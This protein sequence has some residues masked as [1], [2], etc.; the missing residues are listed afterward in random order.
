M[1][2]ARNGASG[3]AEGIASPAGLALVLEDLAIR[4]RYAT[5]DVS[6]QQEKARAQLR[7]LQDHHGDAWG[8]M[9]AVAEAFGVAW[10]AAQD[11]DAAIACYSRALRAEDA[12]ASVKAH[13]Q[14]GKLLIER[15]WAIA[16]DPGA[17]DATRTL[18]REELA[19]ALR[20]LQTLVALQP[21]F[22][23][24][25][26]LG[27]AWQRQAQL[28]AREGLGSESIGSLGMAQDAYRRAEALMADASDPRLGEAGL[29]RMA[30][31]LV[32]PADNKAAPNLDNA[33]LARTRRSVQASHDKQPDF[34]SHADL[35]LVDLFEALASNALAERQPALA[36]AYAALQAQVAAVPRWAQVLDGVGWVLETP[37][38]L[39]N[40]AN[41]GAAGKL[42]RQL[43]G[44]AQQ[45]T[46]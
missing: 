18:M 34:Q 9:G 23:R 39:K 22:E 32:L 42:L 20:E 41:R 4:T 6:S 45:Q 27:L 46:A 19:T 16:E 44:Y 7:E 36:A 15:A 8:G 40:A 13:E 38:L 10:E 26:L 5:G 11:P 35:I 2:D 14:L 12:S 3:V 21:T 29:R 30:V 37:A 1:R 43:R 25:S 24:L 17:N 28:Q 31:D 33:V